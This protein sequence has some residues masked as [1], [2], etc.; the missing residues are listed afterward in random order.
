MPSGYMTID[1]P[2]GGLNKQMSYRK[3]SPGTTPDCLN[4]MPVD[5]LEGRLRGG[6]RP[7]LERTFADKVGNGNPV[8]MISRV[9]TA[10]QDGFA[11][12][13][14]EFTED[15][16]DSFWT[17]ASWLDGAPEL[18]SV[19]ESISYISSGGLVRDMPD[20]AD[21]SKAYVFEIYISPYLDEHHG[22]YSLWFYLNDTTPDATQDGLTIELDFTDPAGIFTAT[23]RSFDGGVETAT[24]LDTDVDEGEAASGWF[25]VIIDGSTLYAYWRHR[26]LTTSYSI[27]SYGSGGTTL[28]FGMDCTNTDGGKCIVDVARLQYM[29]DF[30]AADQLRQFTIVSANKKIYQDTWLNR[31]DEVS[32]TG[33]LSDLANLES[34]EYLQKLYIA[35]YDGGVFDE[36]SVVIA[37]DGVT[38]TKSGIDFSSYGISADDHVVTITNGTGSV[39]DG[40]YAISAVATG[41][42]TLDST[43]GGSGTAS[44]RVDRTIREY[45]PIAKTL[46]NLEADPGKGTVQPGCPLIAVYRER[47]VTGAPPT[48]PHAYFMSRQGD[49]GDWDY[50]QD[51]AGA[52]IAGT[53]ANDGSVGQ[54]LT[55]LI[56]FKNDYLIL[57]CSQSMWVLRGD[58]TSGGELDNLSV[59]KGIIHRGAWCRSPN[60]EIIFLSQNGVYVLSPGDMTPMPVTEGKLPRDLVNVD[61]VNTQISMSFDYQRNGVH[62]FLT[63]KIAGNATH[64]WI[65]W[66]SKSIWPMNY[67][68]DHEPYCTM[69]FV[70][71]GSVLFG[72]RDGY[73]RSFR[74]IL[75]KDDGES[76]SS[77]ITFAPLMLNPKEHVEGV[78]T[79]IAAAVPSL[80]GSVTWEVLVADS[81]EKLL[82]ASVFDT[83]TWD[84]NGWQYSSRPRARGRVFALRLRGATVENWMV[85]SISVAIK[86]GGRARV[87]D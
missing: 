33:D 25:T 53:P 47:L 76:K 35:D 73:I 81:T 58:P 20:D 30:A 44:V 8:R 1:F 6:S 12:T 79:D 41:N 62:L 38:L 74:N 69:D 86:A 78:M 82:S 56:P 75:A 23:A 27:P 72:C 17:A 54:P 71:N 42:M 26:E 65:D 39:T 13:A 46:T 66:I 4:V 2:L 14:D 64:Y 18:S 45:D 83:G 43:V 51:D 11:W 15:T 3:Q 61:P 24:A 68:S 29:R 48:A 55:A 67:H 63:P 37:A 5:V 49:F 34:A 80:S 87:I 40:V 7:G 32:V 31:L 28:G 16:I 10:P 50:S 85:E 22:K 9:T 19:G 59:A 52:A 57:G 36:D 70:Q 60:N 84:R 21:T 77:Y